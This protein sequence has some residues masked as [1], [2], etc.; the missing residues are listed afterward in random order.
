MAGKRTFISAGGEE[1]H[2]RVTSQ[3]RECDKKFCF[4]NYV[5]ADGSP[6]KDNAA[7]SIQSAWTSGNDPNSLIEAKIR[8]KLHHSSIFLPDKSLVLLN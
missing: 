2:F 3:L 7:G 6:Q 8:R 1:K 5:I 4:C